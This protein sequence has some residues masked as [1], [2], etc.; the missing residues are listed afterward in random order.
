MNTKDTLILFALPLL[1][2]ILV[3][4]GLK[5]SYLISLLLFFGI[6]CLYLSFKNK[7]K[8]AK[9]ALFSLLVG[10]PVA[11]IFQLVA[12]SD[13]SWTVPQSILPWRLFGITPLEDFLWMFLTLFTLLLFYEY[14]RKEEYNL[15]L[16]KRFLILIIALFSLAG[17][18]IAT[19]LLFPSLLN[20]PYAYT[21]L[22]TVFFLIPVI[23]FLTR[24][25]HYFSRFI[26]VTLFFFFIHLLFEITGVLLNHWQFT[27]TNYLGWM[28]FLGVKFPVEEFVF[29]LI[30][31]GFSAGTYYEFI[32]AGKSAKKNA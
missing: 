26:P 10:F 14:Y 18:I 15:M 12:Y 21:W 17:A 6:P 32:N 22:G 5:I 9:L 20:I 29:V 3:I 19:H 13:H 24:N 30:L 31:G 1:I 11:I 28:S 23:V 25:P 2:F 8:V 27:G 16:P 4:S 7:K